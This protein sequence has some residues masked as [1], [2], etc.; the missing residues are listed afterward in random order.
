MLMIPMQTFD[1]KQDALIVVIGPDNLARMK[2]GDPAE[3]E[4]RRSGKNL[5][6]PT[7]L[8]CYEEPS[9]ELNRLVQAGD[10][11]RLI[12]FLQRGWEFQP[13]RGDHD[14]GPE[15]IFEGN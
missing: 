2:N 11:K 14:R 9:P 8:L 3:A 1:H 4:L 12:K 5:V 6:N 7:I 15:S 10:L 13:E